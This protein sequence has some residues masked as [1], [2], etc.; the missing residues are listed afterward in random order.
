MS[1][2]PETDDEIRTPEMLPGYL[3]ER[4]MVDASFARRLERER[5]EA[6]RLAEGFEQALQ[7]ITNK[8]E[9]GPYLPVSNLP[10]K[11]QP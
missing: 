3:G 7:I 11:K 5:D 10:W 4:E 9:S 1:D 2:T 6:R 8:P